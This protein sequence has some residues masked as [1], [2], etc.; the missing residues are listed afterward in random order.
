MDDLEQKLHPIGAR[1]RTTLLALKQEEHAAKGY[2]FDGELYMH[3]FWYYQR[4]LLEREL[5]LDD[6]KVK[7]HFPVSK[8]VP[9][10]LEIYQKLLGVQF[11]EVKGA[12]LWHPGAC[13]FCVHMRRRADAHD[14][15]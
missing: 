13:F 14:A 12:K 11:V 1:E 2:P 15:A 3:D 10:I 8:V 5:E 7:E 4:R 9:A 6:Q